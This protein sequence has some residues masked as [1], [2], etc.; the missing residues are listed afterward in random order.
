[1]L[2]S[3]TKILKDTDFPLME[4]IIM[5]PLEEE[6]K[7]Y[8]RDSSRVNDISKEVRSPS[9]RGSYFLSHDRFSRLTN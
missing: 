8:L 9:S 3:E 6:A 1:M 4:R 7:I 2:V 5:G